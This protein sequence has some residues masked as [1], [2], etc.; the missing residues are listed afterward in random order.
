MRRQVGS[1]CSYE[2][3]CGSGPDFCFSDVC[4]N[5]A[6]D[7]PPMPVSTQPSPFGTSPDGT[8]RGTQGYTCG[9]IVGVC[10][11]VF[12]KCGSFPTECGT[13]WYF[14]APLNP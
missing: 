14:L 11:N 12:G 7:Q 2:D 5:G 13:G 10:C 4:H 8:C 1:C 3:V 9:V 6:C